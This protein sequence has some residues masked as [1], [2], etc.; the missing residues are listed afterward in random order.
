MSQREA[1]IQLFCAGKTNPEIVK[2]L[3]TPKS[4]VWDAVNRYKELGTSDDYP[5][6]GQPQ[7]AHTST[8]I[9]AIREQIRSSP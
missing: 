9:K 3:N 4:T 1:I 7:T 8:K 5:R 2:I 6:S